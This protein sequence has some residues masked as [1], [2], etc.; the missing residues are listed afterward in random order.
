M[1]DRALDLDHLRRWIGKVEEASDI[2]TAQL[3]K[4]M[5]ATLFLDPGEPKAGDAAPLTMHWCLA[6]VSGVRNRPRRSPGPRRLPAAG[7][8]AAA[9]VGGRQDRF[10]RPAA[11]RRRGRRG[12]SEIANVTMKTGGT[13]SLCFVT[14]NHSY[15]TPRGVAIREAQ[16]IVYR[17]R[18]R[19][20]ASARQA[21]PPAPKAQHSK[22]MMAD[23]V[24]LF[25]YS[26]L[27]F[28]GH[29]IHYDR[30]Y[31]TGVEGYPGLIVHGPLQAALL[32][33]YAIQLRGGKPPKSFSHR[34]V[35]PLFDGDFAVNAQPTA[36][37]FELWTTNPAGRPA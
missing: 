17:D 14:V 19:P 15:S 35:N 6:A 36:D 4:G 18:R 16:N 34:G 13:G 32:L 20:T 37:G 8:A 26:A 21:P 10:R 29:R 33:E 27:T 23:P 1:S 5:R 22:A 2:V 3:V 28:N 9:H 12:R 25:R 11:R 24:M 31:V 7:A 30:P